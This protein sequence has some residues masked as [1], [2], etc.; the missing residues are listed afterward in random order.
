MNIFSHPQFNTSSRTND[1]MLLKVMLIIIIFLKLLLQNEYC[2]WSFWLFFDIRVYLFNNISEN[3]VFGST[4]LDKVTGSV[5]GW[6]M[7]TLQDHSVVKL[8]FMYSLLQPFWKPKSHYFVSYQRQYWSDVYSGVWAT[9][10]LWGDILCWT[11]W[12]WGWNIFFI[13]CV[14]IKY[15]YR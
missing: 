1:I 3:S 5:A 7:R 10:V 6:A 13:L 8:P 2:W 9:A 4:N 12:K 11:E 14:H 15:K